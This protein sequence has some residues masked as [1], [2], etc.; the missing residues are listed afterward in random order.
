MS[1]EKD[2][3]NTMK[4]AITTVLFLV[5]TY[6]MS[7]CSTQATYYKEPVKKKAQTNPYST[8]KFVPPKPNQNVW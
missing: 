4:T 2:L 5:F 7:A 3:S 8:Y 6:F 1:L